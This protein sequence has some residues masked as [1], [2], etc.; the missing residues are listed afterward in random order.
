MVGL[1]LVHRLRP[2]LNQHWSNVLCLLG[3]IGVLNDERT[4]I[5]I[6]GPPF[7]YQ[8]REMGWIFLIEH[9]IYLT[10]YLHNFNKT[11]SVKLKNL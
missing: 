7:Y 1:T 4:N 6:G 9:I 3:T 2:P 11:Y 10:S 8:R 5:H